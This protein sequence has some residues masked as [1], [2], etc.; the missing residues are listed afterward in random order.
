MSKK[1]LVKEAGFIE[2]IKS[3]FNAKSKGKEQKFINTIRKYDPDLADNWSKWN[4][5]ADRYLLTMKKYWE[6]KGN[7]KKAKEIQDILDTQF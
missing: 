1:I 5:S 7:T 3:F 2:F 4:D 6:D